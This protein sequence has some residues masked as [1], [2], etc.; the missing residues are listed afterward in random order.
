MRHRLF[1]FLVACVVAWPQLQSLHAKVNPPKPVLPLPTDH[2]VAWQRMETYAFIHYGPDTYYGDDGVEWGYGNYPVDIFNPTLGYCDVDQWVESLKAGGMKGVILTAK[3]HDGFCLWPT[4]YTDY[5]IKNS[6]YKNGKGD[7]VG[8]LAEACRRH[9][10]KFGV[11]LSPWDRHQATYATPAYVDYYKKQLRELLSNYGEL[12]EVWFDGANGGDGWYGGADEKRS[13]D[14]EHY[15]DFPT[16]FSYVRELQPQ[17]IIFSNGGPGCRWVGNED[18]IAGE[19]NW[20][21]LRRGDDRPAFDASYSPTGAED[22]EVWVPA[23]CDVSIR[24]PHW[25]YHEADNE[26]GILTSDQLVDL[27]YKN[28]GRNATF[29]L[30]VPVTRTGRMHPTDVAKL[31][32]FREKLDRIFAHNLLGTAKVKASNVR[33]SAYKAKNVVN[34]DYDRYW[35][36]ADGV[37]SGTLTFT[38]NGRQ[39]FNRIVLQEYIPLGQRVK[40]FCAEWSNDGTTWQKI[41][42]G[43]Q[44]TTI[45]HKRI[46]VFPTVTARM[47]RIRFIDAR[48]PLCINAVGAYLAE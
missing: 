42:C 20:S 33:G 22:G 24:R 17:A 16:L 46:L 48:G 37:N 28:V 10:L 29:L 27:Y 19:T 21:M 3:H 9:G 35:A 26:K 40:S 43:E 44:T 1:L 7:V 41:D 14:K 13:I 4:K 25:F 38:M 45:G 2:Q 34:G 5:S 39:S 36:T 12:F 47:L 11:Y 32:A 31:K 15:Y 8:E 18:G 23:E 30:N 6:P